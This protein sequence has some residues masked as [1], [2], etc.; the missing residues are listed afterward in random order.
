MTDADTAPLSLKFPQ[1]NSVNHECHNFQLRVCSCAYH[2][3]FE[4]VLIAFGVNRYDRLEDK[5]QMPTLHPGIG[6]YGI[7]HWYLGL[8]RV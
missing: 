3:C 6:L 1:F 4:A 2:E 5:V 7:I 8:L